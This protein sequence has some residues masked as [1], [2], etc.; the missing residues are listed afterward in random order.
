MGV[1]HHNNSDYTAAADHFQK[2]LK[3]AGE[4][5]DYIHYA[6]AATK[7]QQG[8]LDEGLAELK[9]AA[10]IDSANLCYASNDP[11]FEPLEEHPGFY[12]LLG[13]K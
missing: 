13:I 11:D 8:D 9:K 5:A 10:K 3:S 12:E 6:W 4:G 2:A 7:V 1:F